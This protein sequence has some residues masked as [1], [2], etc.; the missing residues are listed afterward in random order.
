MPFSLT[1]VTESRLDNGLTVLVR[2]DHTVPI[3]TCMTWYRVGSRH[4]PSGA[5]G[6]SHLVEHMLFKGTAGIGK[7]R[8][9]LITAVNGGDNNA[10]T[11]HDYTSYYFTFA[12]DR[13]WPSLEIEAD[14]MLNAS[15]DPAELELERRVILEEIRMSLDNPWEAMRQAVDEA[16]FPRHPYGN[17]V[18]GRREDLAGLN[19]ETVTDFYRR[20]YRPDNCLLVVVGDVDRGLLLDKVNLLFGGLAGKSGVDGVSA[21]AE[22]APTATLIDLKRPGGVVRLLIGLPAPAFRHPDF[23]AVQVLDRVLGQGKLSRLHRRLLEEDRAV[24]LV[25]TEV[26][27]TVDPYRLFLRLELRPRVSVDAVLETV[28]EELR[29]LARDPVEQAELRKAKNQCVTQF[30]WALEG[31]LDQAFQLGLFAM[32]DRWGR[33][34]EYVAAIEGVGPDHLLR[35]AARYCDPSKA[36]VCAMTPEPRH[37]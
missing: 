37:A 17:P 18:I 12:S 34:G 25:D 20:H 1:E 19:R 32:L 13:W 14:R 11:A 23:H 16:A 31:T 27:E 8:I 3:V 2:E 22:D 15:F 33:V 30:L 4:E 9:D 7:G 5:T 10:F 6:L 29:R 24:S 21:A 35:A 36:V 26:E 28:F